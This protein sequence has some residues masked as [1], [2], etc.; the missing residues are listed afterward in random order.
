MT[1]SLFDIFAKQNN[2]KQTHKITQNRNFLNKKESSK[3]N[4]KA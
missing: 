4:E 2:G 3:Q 1:V